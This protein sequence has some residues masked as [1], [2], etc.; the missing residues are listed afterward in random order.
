MSAIERSNAS[1]SPPARPGTA[2]QAAVPDPGAVRHFND[3]LDA[4]AVPSVADASEAG[5]IP[6]VD[7]HG[8]GSGGGGGGSGE[9]QDGDRQPAFRG[10]DILGSLLGAGP[11]QRAEAE[12]AASSAGL[13]ELVEA[14]TDRLLV[15]QD[16]TGADVVRIQLR[17][18]VFDGAEVVISR[19]HGELR[20][21]LVA[22][23]QEAEAQLRR[24]LPRLSETL[25]ARLPEPVSVTVAS[26]GAGAG[27][28]GGDDAEPRSRGLLPPLR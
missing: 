24:L 5:I 28:Q 15:G 11:A 17:P 18:E 9:Q 3:L 1:N 16:A 12:A 7:G 20:V 26:G 25:S 4:P 23:S 21:E 2:G 22:T 10:D 27:D 6:P 8:G 13:R 14:I 19:Q